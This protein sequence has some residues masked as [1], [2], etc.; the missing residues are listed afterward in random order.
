MKVTFGLRLDGRQGPPLESRLAAPVLGPQGMLALLEL[1]LGLA[2]PHVARSQRVAA[3]LGPL[4]RGDDQKRFYSRSLAVDEVGAASELLTW[5]DEWLLCGWDGQAPENGSMR[6]RE[7]AL[8]EQ[9]AHG[10]VPPGE[11]ERLRFV[12][13]ALQVR[14]VPISE[15]RLLESLERFPPGW[16]AVLAHLPVT[17]PPAMNPIAVGALGALQAAAIASLETGGVEVARDAPDDGTVLVYRAR[18]RAVAQHWLSA[19]CRGA[20]TD[21]LLLC[22]DDGYALDTTLK[23]TG[24]AGCGFDEPSSL[25][26][27]LQT[28]SLALELLWAPVD[29]HRVLE[30]LTH[31]YGP[32]SR[33]ARGR[34]ARAYAKQPGFGG[35]EWGQAKADIGSTE[36]GEALL[37]EVAFWF[38]GQRWARDAGAPV[39][40]ALERAR[41]VAASLRVLQGQDRDDVAAIGAG[42]GQTQDVLIALEELERQGVP[43]VTPRHLEQVLAQATTS[44]A[45]NPLAYPEVG[46]WR[47]ARTAA[48]VAVEPAEELIWWM[49]G[50]PRLPAPSPWSASE[51]AQLAAVGAQLRDPA[52]EMRWLAQDWIRPLLAAKRRLV[53]VL[54]PGGEEEHPVWQL[55]RSVLPGVRVRDIE[56]ELQPK[57]ELTAAVEHLELPRVPRYL[58]VHGSLTSRRKRQSYTSL[59][60]LFNNPA[61]SVLKDVAKL[62]RGSSLAVDVENRLLGTLAHRLLQELFASPDALGWRP[63]QIR[64]W[65][66]NNAEAL[67]EAEGAPLLMQGSG[68]ALHKFRLTAQEGAVALVGHLQRAGV[69]RVESEVELKGTLG[70]IPLVGQIDLLA[71]MPDARCVALDLK[72]TGTTRHAELLKKGDHLQLALYSALVREN[73]GKPPAARGYFIFDTRT[74]IVDTE[75]VFVEARV[76]RPALSADE[77][78]QRARKSWAWRRKQLKDGQVE[79]VDLRLGGIEQFQGPEDALPVKEPRPWDQE[80]LALL[81]WGEEA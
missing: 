13:E 44:G 45:S 20:A 23:A 14:R 72:W 60:E 10:N 46:C 80:Y 34:L 41:R 54:P 1:H 5:R 12:C 27:A 71:H 65:F 36:R 17:P 16:R 29:V 57:R 49:P 33:R 50:S 76:C 2:A 22:E 8:V 59:N 58:N 43:S 28:L 62:Y 75:G 32:F 7:L 37:E 63:E 70:D 64:A 11:G 66:G 25:R 56:D 77:V 18:T 48:V 19:R 39:A 79:V 74:L 69:T 68:V 67:I 15:V 38:E 4:R 9:Q 40:A 47:S 26:P 81:A 31:P 52:Q 35:V 24:A 55:I 30:F 53:L 6:I 42:V 51:R 78:L 61:V 73:L 3:Y 21:R